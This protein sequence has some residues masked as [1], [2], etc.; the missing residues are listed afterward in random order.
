MEN[1]QVW[2]TI[3]RPFEHSLNQSTQRLKLNCANPL[4]TLQGGKALAHAGV[5]DVIGLIMICEPAIDGVVAP[6][7]DSVNLAM[8]LDCGHQQGE[9]HP[10]FGNVPR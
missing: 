8:P 9:M 4:R 3:I 5:D 1:S 7:D 2:G 6:P 10:S